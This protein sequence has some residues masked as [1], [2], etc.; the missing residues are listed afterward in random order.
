MKKLLTLIICIY[1]TI[2]LMAQDDLQKLR[3]GAREVK[4]T[5]REV[6]VAPKK[7]RQ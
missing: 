7:Q 1:S 6:K 5:A 2:A 4:N 3:E